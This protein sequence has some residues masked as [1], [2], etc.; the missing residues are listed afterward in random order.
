MDITGRTMAA[1][2]SGI[3]DYNLKSIVAYSVHAFGP[4][5]KVSNRERY[6]PKN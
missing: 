2:A 3:S 1:A 4:E 6:S 5:E